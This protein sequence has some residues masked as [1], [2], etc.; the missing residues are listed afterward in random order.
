MEV[1]VFKQAIKAFKIDCMI[2]LKGV[3]SE[4][5]SYFCLY[6]L[7]LKQGLFAIFQLKSHQRKEDYSQ[8]LCK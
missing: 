8:F 4:V 7:K 3:F 2:H 6:K 5:L 1:F